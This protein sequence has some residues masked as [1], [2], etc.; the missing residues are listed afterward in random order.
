MKYDTFGRIGSDS[1]RTIR[2]GGRQDP[3]RDG[4]T[5]RTGQDTTDRPRLRSWPAL[6]RLADPSVCRCPLSHATGEI[7]E[8]PVH[9]LEREGEAE[10]PRRR[11]GIELAREPVAPYLSHRV[12]IF[13]ERTRD[14]VHGRERR[15]RRQR[16]AGRAQERGDLGRHAF[17]RLCEPGT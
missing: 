8:V 7:L 3:T 4:R 15:P 2:G 16:A 9:L 1:G 13:G 17:R 11:L 5:V 12:G 14:A 10:N 6:V